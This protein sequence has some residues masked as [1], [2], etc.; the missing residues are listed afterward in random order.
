MIMVIA[1]SC[2]QEG[3]FYGTKSEKCVNLLSLACLWNEMAKIEV[4][5]KNKRVRK[6]GMDNKS[7]KSNSHGTSR[8]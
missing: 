8:T 4:Y 1:V 7:K 2:F 6:Y 3:Y 5:T